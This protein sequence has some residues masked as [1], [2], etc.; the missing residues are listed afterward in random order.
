MDLKVAIDA[1]TETGLP[2]W[3]GLSCK[4][5]D[6]QIYLGLIGR[7]GRETIADAVIASSSPNVKVFA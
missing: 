3:V 5:H 4:N 7:Y 2:V 6:D 1:A